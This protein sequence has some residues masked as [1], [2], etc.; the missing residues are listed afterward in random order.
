MAPR[1]SSSNKKN[2]KK[3]NGGKL[4]FEAELF[5]TADKL[6]GDL[7]PSEHE[8]VALGL[9]FLKYISDPFEALRVRLEADEYAD[10]ED[11][12]L[13]GRARIAQA[14]SEFLASLC[15]LLLPKLMS[16]AIR[17]KDAENMVKEAL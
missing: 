7:E 10:A 1:N 12:P 17:V 9:I 6:R 15:D 13:D 11:P 16:G 4:G 14:E 2:D 8:H 5:L 3:S